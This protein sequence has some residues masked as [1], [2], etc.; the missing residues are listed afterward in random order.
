MGVGRGVA[1]IATATLLSLTAT[2]VFYALSHIIQRTKVPNLLWKIIHQKIQNN[3]YNKI[4]HR[5]YINNMPK[6]IFAC[7]A[8]ELRCAQH[9]GAE[10]QWAVYPPGGGYRP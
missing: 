9:A 6:N 5:T 8:K 1:R 3:S 10:G 7:G 4:L 2:L